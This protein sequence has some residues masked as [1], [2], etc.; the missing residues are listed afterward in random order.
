MFDHIIEIDKAL[1]IYLNGLG[2]ETFDFF[3]L[4]ITNKLLNFILYFILSVIYLKQEKWKQFGLL[5]FTLGIMIL[6]TDQV[7]NIFKYMFARLRPCHNEDISNNI[8]LL[9]SNC[10]GLYGF[11]S[12]HA[13]NSFALAV[14]FSTLFFN[15]IN[16]LP[17][18][19]LTF[20]S[21]VSY[22]RIYIGVHY[23]F[24]V[25]SGAIFGILSGYLFY[26]LFERYIKIKT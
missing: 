8:R 14:F 11:F 12:A 2:T 16:K 18:L 25:V 15:K 21:L 17:F 22:S 3:W 4:L 5:L 13:S 1:F 19:L 26:I 20:A 24:D 23:P 10:G 9:K 6:F 7:T